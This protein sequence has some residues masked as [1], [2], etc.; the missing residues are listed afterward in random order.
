[1]GAIKREKERRRNTRRWRTITLAL[2]RT[3]RCIRQCCLR[4]KKAAKAINSAS[5]EGEYKSAWN[6]ALADY[7]SRRIEKIRASDLSC[8]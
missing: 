3:T 8:C 1:M 4:R 2:R 5:P 6:T 7:E